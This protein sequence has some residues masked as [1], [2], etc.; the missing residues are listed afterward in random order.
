VGYIERRK[1]GIAIYMGWVIRMGCGEG[2]KEG[3]KMG[4]FK[5]QD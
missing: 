4:C 2:D 3:K 1:V 5:A